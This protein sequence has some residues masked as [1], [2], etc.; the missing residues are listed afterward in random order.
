MYCSSGIPL[1]YIFTY[2]SN[3]WNCNVIWYFLERG[4]IVNINNHMISSAS[5]WNQQ[6]ETLNYQ[7][8]LSMS[9]YFLKEV[10]LNTKLHTPFQLFHTLLKIQQIACNRIDRSS[11]HRTSSHLVSSSRWFRFSIVKEFV[12]SSL[13]FRAECEH[14]WLL[15]V[16]AI[17]ELEVTVV[18]LI[19]QSWNPQK[20]GI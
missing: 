13:C 17:N 20:T 12:Q 11:N 4:K 9:I 19:P 16:K 14:F 1:R 2:L 7:I 8:W 10:T 6:E 5:P 18:W 3:Y 15:R